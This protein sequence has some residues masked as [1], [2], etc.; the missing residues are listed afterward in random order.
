RVLE[1]VLAS[2]AVF[3]PRFGARRGEPVGA[4]ETCYL[5][6]ACPRASQ[7]VVQRGL[8]YASRRLRLTKRPVHGVEQPERLDSAVTQVAF[9]ALEG[10]AAADIHIPQIEGGIAIDNPVR[11]DFAGTAC[12]LDADRVE[13]RGEVQAAHLGYL[14]EQVPV[15]G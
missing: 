12:G 13:A 7:A 4:L 1:P 8:A 10:R 6:E 15:I 2:I 5:A 9:V 14:S 3:V 11:Q